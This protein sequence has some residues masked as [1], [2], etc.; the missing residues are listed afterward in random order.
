MENP[1]ARPVAFRGWGKGAAGF[2][3]SLEISKKSSSRL[4]SLAILAALLLQ[5]CA[6]SYHRTTTAPTETREV[7][8]GLGRHVRLPA[9]I[10]RIVSLAPNLTEI[11]YAIGAGNRLVGDTTF[12]DYP[13]EARTVAKVG[14][15]IHPSL[16]RVVALRP[17]V[18][19]LSTS[20][21]LE[22]FTQQLEQQHITVF[23]TDAHDLETVFRSVEQLGELLGQQE[24]AGRVAAL[25]RSRASAVEERVKGR[26][27]VRVFYQLS[28]EPLYTA[29]KSSYITDMIRRAGGVSVTQDVEGEWLRLSDETALAAQPE[30]VILATADSMGGGNTEVAA[31]L[32]K[33]PAAIQGHV[34]RINGDFLSRP[35]PRL[36]EGLEQ[37][38]RSLHPEAF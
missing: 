6:C 7:L 28:A 27:P 18:V 38:A 17:Q 13:P 3:F 21:Q 26:K 23:V 31:P 1:V 11:V 30:A 36:I 5:L 10:D 16:E 8:D 33:S 22:A 15:T 12:C 9:K 14:D 37:M 25:L 24:Q 29:G 2:L 32:A 19:L 34:Y 20:S 35:G 4:C